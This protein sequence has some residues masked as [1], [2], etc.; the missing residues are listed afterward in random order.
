MPLFVLT[1]MLSYV[2]GS[3][4]YETFLF[5]AGSC[6]CTDTT[7]AGCIMEAVSG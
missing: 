2:S 5:M 6:T 4:I 3:R 1:L 7:T